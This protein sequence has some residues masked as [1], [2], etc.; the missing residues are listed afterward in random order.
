MLLARHRATF[1]TSFNI[2][3]RSYAL[4]NRS[5]TPNRIAWRLLMMAASIQVKQ[6]AR[7]ATIQIAV[8]I[9]ATNQRL[10][11][12]PIHSPFLMTTIR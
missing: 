12:I 1:S 3:E 6:L 4:A 10:D 7:N 11:L 5:D 9:P 8:A 2:G